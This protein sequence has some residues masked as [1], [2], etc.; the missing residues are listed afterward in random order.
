MP[1]GNVYALIGP[2]AVGK[3]TLLDEM[4]KRI[5]GLERMPSATEREKRPEEVHGKDKFFLTREEFEEKIKQSAFIEWQ[6]VH[7][8]RYG[9]LKKVIEERIKAGQ[10]YIADVEVL[11]AMKLKEIY[12]KNVFLIFIIPPSMKELSKRIDA[13]GTGNEKE[14]ILRLSRTRSEMTYVAKCDIILLNDKLGEAFNG[15]ENII[16]QRKTDQFIS[17]SW[18]IKSIAAQEEHENKKE[19][20]VKKGEYPHEAIKNNLKSRGINFHWSDNC[21]FDNASNL[22]LNSIA[23]FKIKIKKENKLIEFYYSY[24]LEK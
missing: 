13:R 11:G 24:F 5:G 15:L 9:V 16:R 7:G 14:K 10:D 20:F 2:T 1:K 17:R 8:H 23:P 3:N 18:K 21:L 12:K 22:K 6:L 4:V 19:F